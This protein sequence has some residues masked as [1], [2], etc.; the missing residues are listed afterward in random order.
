MSKVRITFFISIAFILFFLS[1][2]FIKDFRIDASSDTLVSQ[3]DEDFVYFNTY[4]KLFKSDNFLVLAK[5]IQK[6][7]IENSLIILS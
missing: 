3:K 6:K 1:A 2:F 4:K 7:L 5:K